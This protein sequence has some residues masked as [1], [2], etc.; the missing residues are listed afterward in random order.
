MSPPLGADQENKMYT[1][2]SDGLTVESKQTNQSLALAEI[3]AKCL[4]RGMKAPQRITQL[5]NTSAAAPV[6]PSFGGNMD[7]FK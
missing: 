2:T 4:H 5:N 1:Y 6:P 3:R 7:V